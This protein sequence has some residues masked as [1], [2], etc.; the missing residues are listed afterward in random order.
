[1][2]RIGLFLLT[3]IAVL[4]VFS[5]VFG[6]LSSV[7]GLGGVHGANGLNYTSLAVMCLLYGMIGSIISLFLSKWMAKKSTGTV[8]IK[9]P[10]NGTEQWLVD[11]VAKQASLAGIGMPEVGIFDNPQPNAFATGWNK[12]NALVAVSTGLLHTMTAEEV[13]A[14]LAHEIG[15]VANGDMVTLALIQGVVN[16]FVMFFARI[17]GNFVDRAIFRNESDSPGIGYF[18]TSIVMD[19]LLGIL[20]SAIVMWFSRLREYRA[21]EMGARLAGRDNMIAA[22][23]ALRPAEARPDQ[24]PESMKAFAISSGQSQSF[25]IASLFRSHPTLD[26]RIASLQKLPS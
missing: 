22:L 23:N 15:H 26:D 14:V 8:I 12:N 25:S 3:N 5:I 9:T 6:V 1:M 18:V 24:M 4:V 19:I 2:M 16:A 7:F 13:E 17:I 21:D 20:A 10:H 11:T